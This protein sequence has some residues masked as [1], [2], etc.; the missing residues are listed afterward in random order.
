MI[1]LISGG[2]RA[3]RVKERFKSLFKYDYECVRKGIN[4]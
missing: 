1:Q 4:G 2:D 3:E